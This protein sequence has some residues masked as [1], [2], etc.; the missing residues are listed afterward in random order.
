MGENWRKALCSTCIASLTKVESASVCDDLVTSVEKELYATIQS[1][2]DSLVNP[3]ASQPSTSES[4]QGSLSVPVLW[5]LSE[6]P[7]TREKLPSAPSNDGSEEE[8][9]EGA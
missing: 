8:E 6:G 2:C 3:A 5:T 1:F 9:S 4:S 7:S